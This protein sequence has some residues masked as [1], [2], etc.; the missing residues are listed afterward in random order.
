MI[1]RLNVTEPAWV[2]VG[3]E[4]IY[5]RVLSRRDKLNVTIHY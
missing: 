5:Y 1:G 4:E 3:L 2:L